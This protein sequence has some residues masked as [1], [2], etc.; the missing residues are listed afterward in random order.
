MDTVSSVLSM[1]TW[2]SDVTSDGQTQPQDRPSRNP[3]Q[4]AKQKQAQVCQPER[5]SLGQQ[6][7]QGL[8][9]GT[10]SYG[11]CKVNESVKPDSPKS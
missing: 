4:K 9:E 2:G 6:E 1:Q 3:S 11:H 5:S 8:E 7:G 10:F